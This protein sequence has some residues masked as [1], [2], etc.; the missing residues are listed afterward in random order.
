[1]SELES[2]QNV[3]PSKEGEL[4]PEQK[5][6]Q[7]IVEYL[8]NAEIESP[9]FQAFTDYADLEY[10]NLRETLGALAAPSD[11]PNIDFVRETIRQR[12]NGVKGYLREHEQ[13]ISTAGDYWRAV[14]DISSNP[15]R[16]AFDFATALQDIKY[17]EIKKKS[18]EPLTPPK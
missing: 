14:T 11:T 6:R 9:R 3:E 18:Q 15:S 12:K 4:T 10:A 2:G 1:M 13:V 7:K 5:G 16:G 8:S 17:T